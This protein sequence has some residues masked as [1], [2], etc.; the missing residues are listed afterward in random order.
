LK[1]LKL[2]GMSE[3]LEQELTLAQKETLAPEEVVHRLVVEEFHYRQEKSVLY[4]IK[5]ALVLDVELLP[6]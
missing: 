5:H 2:L 3:A 1:S 6:L 4:R